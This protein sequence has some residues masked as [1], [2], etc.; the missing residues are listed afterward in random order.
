MFFENIISYCRENSH[1]TANGKTKG[2]CN[3]K[4]SKAKA[5]AKQSK[6][7]KPMQRVMHRNLLVSFSA[8][9]GTHIDRLRRI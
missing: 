1:G 6:A 3:K 4:Q 8:A 9:I 5:K 7:N 2:T